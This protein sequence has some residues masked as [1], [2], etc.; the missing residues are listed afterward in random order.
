MQ[1]KVI[2]FLQWVVAGGGLILGS[3]AVSWGFEPFNWFQKLHS[4]V[5]A[6]IVLAFSIG[7]G[8]GAVYILQLP[9]EKFAALLPYGE[10][11]VGTFLAWGLAQGFHYKNPNRKVEVKDEER[12]RRAPDG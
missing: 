8:V 7:L 10:V 1:D 6:G 2:P 11:V 5:R 9:P 12:G 3:W 4:R